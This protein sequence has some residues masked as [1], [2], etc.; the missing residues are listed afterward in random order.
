MQNME[1]R[2]MTSPTCTPK[3]C[4]EENYVLHLLPVSCVLYV[5]VIILIYL[6]I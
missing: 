4:K 5:S 6:K 3:D 2:L 1:L